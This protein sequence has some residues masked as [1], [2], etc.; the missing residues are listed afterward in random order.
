MTSIINT[1]I[2]SHFCLSCFFPSNTVPRIE[3]DKWL[4]YVE[5][6]SLEDGARTA[7]LHVRIQAGPSKSPTDFRPIPAE[8]HAGSQRLRSGHSRSLS[9]T[10]AGPRYRWIFRFQ[11]N[12]WF[13]HNFSWQKHFFT[14]Q[15]DILSEAIS[16]WR[17]SLHKELALC[18]CLLDH[19]QVIDISTEITE[20]KGDSH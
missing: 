12:F 5:F 18:C 17:F 9:R 4:H 11:F 15:S 6:Q 14:F 13:M 16:S 1:F 2:F 19:R 7:H 3:W 8:F 20:I 10:R